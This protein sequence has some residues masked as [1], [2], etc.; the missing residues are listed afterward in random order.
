M[1]VPATALV[2]IHDGVRPFASRELITKCFD[3]AENTG[4]GVA[5]VV[6]KDSIRK[7]SG[8]ES[9]NV[10]RSAFRLM[11]TPQTFQ[12]D[13]IKAAFANHTDT[14]ATDDATIAENSGMKINLIE[15]DYRN[16]K[17]TTPE[18]ITIAQALL[19]TKLVP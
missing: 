1:K 12:S 7:I 6:P 17:I 15:G 9:Y 8:D 11:Q 2:A 16:I 5:V 3:S 19:N 10:E 14:R 13:L 18:D 4:S